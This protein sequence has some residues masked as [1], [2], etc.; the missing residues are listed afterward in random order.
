V[1][2]CSGLENR[3]RL[4][5]FPGFESLAHRHFSLKN[6]WLPNS[7]KSNCFPTYQKKI[8]EIQACVDGLFAA[9]ID[10]LGLALPGELSAYTIVIFT[11]AVFPISRLHEKLSSLTSPIS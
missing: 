9:I 10:F 4:V 7:K 2:E 8:A 1:A 3:R 5:A 6:S 11:P